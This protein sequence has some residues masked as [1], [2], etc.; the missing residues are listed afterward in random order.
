MISFLYGG[1]ISN[2]ATIRMKLKNN[3]DIPMD[4]VEWEPGAP[5]LPPDPIHSA[6][7]GPIRLLFKS[8]ASY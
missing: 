8:R 7:S 1:N 3:T 4:N 2:M 6:N 5:T